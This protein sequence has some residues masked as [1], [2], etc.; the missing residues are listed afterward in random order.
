MNCQG[1]TGLF[2]T[3]K[4]R[5]TRGDIRREKGLNSHKKHASRC[6]FKDDSAREN[7]PLF[8]N[9][10]NPVLLNPLDQTSCRGV[11]TALYENKLCT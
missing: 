10:L 11:Y 7:T 4:D 3:T 9:G 2:W 1:G 5:F 6:L 8:S